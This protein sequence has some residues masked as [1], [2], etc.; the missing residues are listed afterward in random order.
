MRCLF[1]KWDYK[2]NI[3]TPVLRDNGGI[4]AITTRGR[5]CLK[6]GLAQVKVSGRWREPI[7]YVL[8]SRILPRCK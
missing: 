7:G 4:V 8:E 2:E 5:K 3:T 1:H 6:C